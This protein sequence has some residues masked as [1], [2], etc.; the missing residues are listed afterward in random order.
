[1]SMKT[2]AQALEILISQAKASPHSETVPLQDALGRVLANDVISTV[3]VPPMDN[4]QMDGYV[5]RAEDIKESGT[6]LPVMQRIPAGHLGSAL[7]QNTAARIFT[8]ASI[9]SGA[10]AVVMQEDCEVIGAPDA[11]GLN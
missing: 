8:G 11:S 2:A 3:N 7:E 5:L 1:M 10:T 6:I 4:T 9:P